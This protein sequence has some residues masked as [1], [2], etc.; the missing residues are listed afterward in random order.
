[1]PLPLETNPVSKPGGSG[2]FENCDGPF[3]G[4]EWLVVGADYNF[5]ALIERVAHQSVRVRLRAGAR[6][7]WDRAEPAK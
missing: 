7:R 2:L 6:R 5:R 3:A 4:D 1:M